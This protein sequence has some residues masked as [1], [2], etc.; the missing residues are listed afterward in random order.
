MCRN[1]QV[2][3][4]R[5]VAVHFVFIPIHFAKLFYSLFDLSHG[6]KLASPLSGNADGEFLSTL[7]RRGC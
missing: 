1:R 7:K 5:A 3:M 4:C 2:L 6:G